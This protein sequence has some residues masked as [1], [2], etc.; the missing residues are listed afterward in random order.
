MLLFRPP[1]VLFNVLGC[2]FDAGGLDLNNIK[3]PPNQGPDNGN[4]FKQE[5]SVGRD[6]N[7]FERDGHP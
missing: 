4:G 2:D 7:H 5:M 3:V 1:G 6:P